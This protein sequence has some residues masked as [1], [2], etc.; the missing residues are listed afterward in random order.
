MTRVFPENGAICTETCRRNLIT[1]I[2]YIYI[3][4]YTYIHIF[5]WLVTISQDILAEI[6]EQ[7]LW[8]SP[9]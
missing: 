4:K 9:K 7:N 5:N 8:P 2:I 3:Y 6:I 1:N